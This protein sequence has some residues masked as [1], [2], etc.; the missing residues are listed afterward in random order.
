M[1]YRS[2]RRKDLALG[3][4]LALASAL[5]LSATASAQTAPAPAPAPVA[6]I[7]P[8]LAAPAPVLPVPG[9]SPQ[10]L[11]P[12]PA[13]AAPGG[14]SRADLEAEVAQLKAMVNQLSTQV[15]QMAATPAPAAAAGTG[16]G[17]GSPDIGSAASNVTPSSSGGPAAPGQSFPPNPA[18][19]K[20]FDSPATL[21]NKPGS[22]K[23]GPGFEIRSND[24][25]YFFQ[26]HNLTQ[27]D[28]RGYQQGGQTPV[29]DTFGMPRQ[30]FM[31]SGR[32]TRPIGYF[33]SLANGYDVTSMLDAFID[34]NY[35]PRLQFRIGRMKTPFTY[36]FFV[37]PV[38][39][40][41]IGERSLFFNNFGQ[42]RDVGGMAY[43]RLFDGRIDY[44]AGIYNGSR[45]GYVATGDG[46]F[47]SSYLN[48]KPFLKDEG[49]LFENLNIGG[50]VFAGDSNQIALPQQLRTAIATTGN[51][52]IGVPFMTF[53]TNTKEVGNKAFWDLHL[54]YYYRQL[55]IISEWQSGFQDY[56]NTTPTNRV[57][58]PVNSFYV[59]A[60]YLLTGETRS[61]VGIVKPLHPF[62]PKHDQFGLGAW[63]VVGRYQYMD[64]GSQVFN[65]GLAD[66]NNSANRL[67]MTDLGLNWHMTQYVKW[68]LDWE[69]AEFNNPV[70]YAPGKRQSTSD[71]FW[72]RLQLY[73]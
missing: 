6:P 16:Y 36:E 11:A 51:A 69:H 4:S 60:G 73:F 12:A 61:S 53:N 5:G 45:N 67:F 44:A 8:A 49:G 38:Q 68:Y 47:F 20:R 17:P 3:V 43:G 14:M 10:P 30:W 63:E 35:D 42:N 66:P 58:V 62:N 1:Q 32:I 7:A 31:F 65:A 27:V 33:V 40:L 52:V 46:K 39:G 26:F 50:S 21:D 34:F 48:W 55:A 23:F 24:E 13:A 9:V 25:E 59:Q 29:H 37:E 28:Y 15:Q 64:I 70:L 22:V 57:K 19:S 18:A 2:R 72:L 54:A 41:L 56:S 71:M